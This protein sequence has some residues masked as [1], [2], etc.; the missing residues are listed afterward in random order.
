MPAGIPSTPAAAEVAALQEALERT[1]QV[2]MTQ[3]YPAPA[4][5]RQAT[6]MSHFYCESEEAAKAH[7]RSH[8]P[9]LKND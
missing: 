3:L 6:N 9:T 8:L 7:T 4:G 5:G 1:R 2:S